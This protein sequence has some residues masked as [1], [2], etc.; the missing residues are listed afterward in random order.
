MNR[1][2][3]T[4]IA[5]SLLIAGELLAQEPLQSG[6]PV[7]A[8]NNRNGFYPNWVAGPCA[9]QHLCPV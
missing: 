2:L 4:G 9:G 3:L 6:P 1:C 7:G 5:C 8:R